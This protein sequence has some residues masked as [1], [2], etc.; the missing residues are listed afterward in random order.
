MQENVL[1]IAMSGLNVF[2]S[3]P[4]PQ[5]VAGI[6]G[7]VWTKQKLFMAK[8]G[9]SVN[10]QSWAPCWE[11]S[12]TRPSQ[13]FFHWKYEAVNMRVQHTNEALH[14]IS[15]LLQNFAIRIL[16]WGT[17]TWIAATGSGLEADSVC[18]TPLTW[19][20]LT[21]CF[22][23]NTQNKQED[24]DH[25]QKA[26]TFPKLRHHMRSVEMILRSWAA[27]WTAQMKA[28]ACCVPSIHRGFCHQRPSGQ[29]NHDF[30]SFMEGGEEDPFIWKPVEHEQSN[31]PQWITV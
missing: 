7:D 13:M 24:P 12:C 26:K 17:P 6:V 14:S 2:I 18:V 19:I 23:R 25:L 21:E 9:L 29:H 20:L 3:S 15:N 11:K 22:I 4:A 28:S 10:Q 16:L 27:G 31:R 1:K 5:S 8:R 30:C